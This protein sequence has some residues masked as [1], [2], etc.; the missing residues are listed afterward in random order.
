MPIFLSRLHYNALRYSTKWYTP[1]LLLLFVLIT[2]WPMMSLVESSL[3]GPKDYVY[4]FFV[5]ASTTGYGDLSPKLTGGRIV[6]LYVISGGVVA[7]SLLTGQLAAAM[8]EL[9]R[10]IKKGLV[11]LH[12]LRGHITVIGWS[13]PLVPRLVDE[14]T[15]NGSREI[16]LYVSPD[17]LSED[18]L[19]GKVKFRQGFT[20]DADSLQ[21]VCAQA[22]C[23]I[24]NEPDYATALVIVTRLRQAC[25]GVRIIVGLADLDNASL[26]DR[27]DV[28][29]VSGDNA[30]LLA[31]EAQCP[32]MSRVL[33]SLMS[34]RD[35]YDMHPLHVTRD[36]VG[37]MF[38]DLQLALMNVPGRPLAIAVIR[39]GE[40]FMNPH[41]F[42]LNEGDSV[43]YLSP[44]AVTLSEV[45]GLRTLGRLTS[46]N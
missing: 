19:P 6:F 38:Q 35:E 29:C 42:Q 21:E 15:A 27:H 2:S 40:H 41:D 16:V 37:V 3:A 25:P 17:R 7:V 20:T 33:T 31:G 44:R 12:H 22:D 43:I 11:K 14:L 10:R 28:T 18:P 32:G 45:P 9:T 8:I 26:F 34:N 1:L 23:V 36:L 30:H 5:T 46:A 24:V 13:H 4:W 39:R